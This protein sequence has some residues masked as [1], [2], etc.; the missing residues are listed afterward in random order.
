MFCLRVEIFF[1]AKLLELR[2][3]I[4]EPSQEKAY[5]RHPVFSHIGLALFFPQV[6][7]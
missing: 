1:G 4:L 3:K 6:T 7:L 5:R 2:P